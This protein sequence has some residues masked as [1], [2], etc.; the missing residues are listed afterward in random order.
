MK[1]ITEASTNKDLAKRSCKPCET[2]EGKLK[3]T[4]IKTLK[5]QLRGKWK[6][7][8]G[9]QLENSFDFPDFKKALAFVNR[10]GKIAE[11]QGHHPDIF[12]TYGNVRLQ[13]STHHAGGLTENDFILAA[14]V[15]A[16]K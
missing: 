12:L 4:Q 11:E 10:V 7:T 6:L 13:L 2:G 5:Q 15:N 1:D 9:R 14:K 3:E 16:L 8:G